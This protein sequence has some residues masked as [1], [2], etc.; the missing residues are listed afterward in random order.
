MPLL[1]WALTKHP[2]AQS[3]RSRAANGGDKPEQAQAQCV[4]CQPGDAE[5][6]ATPYLPS[7]AR[8]AVTIVRVAR[9]RSPEDRFGRAGWAAAKSRAEWLHYVR[10]RDRPWNV[11]VQRHQTRCSD[12]AAA[13]QSRSKSTG[14]SNR[15]PIKTRA[16]YANSGPI[17]PKTSGPRDG[18]ATQTEGRIAI[19]SGGWKRGRRSLCRS[20]QPTLIGG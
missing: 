7:Q 16:R 6:R 9:D 10:G 20:Y 8:P 11:N 13:R 5:C 1:I 3:A 19:Q 17:E 14:A 2:M 15:W 4:P 12:L 18:A